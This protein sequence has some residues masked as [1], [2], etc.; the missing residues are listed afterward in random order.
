MQYQ[1]RSDPDMYSEQQ[2]VSFM[3]AGKQMCL[4]PS[5]FSPPLPWHGPQVDII[6]SEWMGYFLLRESMLDSV[7]LARDKYLAPGGALYPSH[8]R[9]FL[10]PIRTH[11]ADQRVNE[12]QSGMED[13]AQFL[14]Q[15]KAYYQVGGW[16]WVRRVG[17]SW[18]VGGC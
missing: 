4:L 9:L 15:M 5:L 16:G 10:A 1:Y 6:I 2:G 7:L 12:F 17:V 11:V 8:A 3:V 13:W 18:V 14:Q